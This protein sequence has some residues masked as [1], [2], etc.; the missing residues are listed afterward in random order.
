MPSPA[1]RTTA[2]AVEHVVVFAGG[3]PPLPEAM[4]GVAPAQRVIAADSGMDHA[5]SLG[6][7]VDVL[8]GDLDSISA[9][10]RRQAEASGVRIVE[11]PAV[12]DATDLELALGLALDERPQRVTVVGGHGGR[13]DHL[14][15]NVSLLA[16]PM[17]AGVEVRAV[18]GPALVTI[19]RSAAA[20]R[21]RPGEL[22]SLLPTHGPAIGV[23]TEGLRYPLDAEDLPAGSPRG[24]SNVLLGSDATVTLRSGTLVAVQPE[25]FA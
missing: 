10:G 17:L 4:V 15:A 5:L 12:K 6:A 2:A 14:L 11:H 8:V 9:E 20:L 7:R 23:T 13:V 22:V 19:V 24:V 18:L 1:P 21:G 3:D 25:A 16:S